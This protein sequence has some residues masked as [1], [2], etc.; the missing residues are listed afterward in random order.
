MFRIISIA[1][2][3]SAK[4][5]QGTFNLPPPRHYDHRLMCGCVCVCV[6]TLSFHQP[7][8]L[9]I[10]AT[11]S[12]A[13][14]SCRIVTCES[15]KMQCYTD[16]LSLLANEKK[17]KDTPAQRYQTFTFQFRIHNSK[18]LGTGKYLLTSIAT[19]VGSAMITPKD[20]I[21]LQLMIWPLALSSIQL[22]SQKHTTD[23]GS[24]GLC[25]KF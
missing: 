18:L 9:R 19:K 17:W 16:P 2:F 20:Q 7:N 21:F 13:G 23:C 15:V 25:F 10:P 12:W 22:L 5:M 1:I 24:L 3:V 4:T 6:S 8:H 14:A 11:S